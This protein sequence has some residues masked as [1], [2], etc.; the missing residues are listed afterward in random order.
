[1][2]K[3][4]TPDTQITTIDKKQVEQ[5][6]ALIHIAGE[7][8]QSGNHQMA[9]DLYVM[10]IDRL[11]SAL[12]LE[13]DP[14]LKLAVEHRLSEFRDRKKLNLDQPF[15]EL[16]MAV[17]D[18]QEII[19]EDQ[20]TLKSRFTTMVTNAA[21]YGVDVIKR[22]PIPGAV[23]YSVT[24]AMAGL[25]AVDTTYQLRQRTWNLAVQGVAKALEMDRRYQ[26]HRVVIDRL[27]ITCH[28]LL[29]AAVAHTESPK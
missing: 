9:V 27:V 17:A 6:V 8:D 5:V 25:E 19:D 18:C 13:S 14:T 23:S 28:A 11:L 15:K 22:S 26:V 20:H 2:W 12:P 7:M 10:G 29:Q 1:M 16:M 3:Q 4:G 21:S 24:C